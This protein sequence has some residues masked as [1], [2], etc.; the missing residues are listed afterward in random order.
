M[1]R[2]QARQVLERNCAPCHQAPANQANFSFC[3]DVDMLA[4]TTSSTGKKNLVPGAPEQSALFERVANGEMPPA[5]VKQRPTEAD[6][7][8]LRQ[9]IAGC[10]VLG[11]GDFGNL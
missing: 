7:A 5:I 2:A 1:L 4:A 6:V 8:V 11:A 9:W 3:L 10:V